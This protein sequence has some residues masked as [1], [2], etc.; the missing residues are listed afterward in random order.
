MT[1]EK[2]QALPSTDVKAVINGEI[3]DANTA[4]LMGKGKTVLFGLPGAF[5]PTCSQ[6]HLP[7]YVVQ[8]DA[9]KA[10]GVDRVICMSVNDGFVM[11]AWGEASNA[12][13][14]IMLADG[15]GDFAQALGLEMDASGFMMG[16]RCKRFAMIIEDG[17][18]TGVFVEAPKEFEVSSAEYIL[19]QL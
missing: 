9:L 11:K 5:T 4:D 8:F 16:S 13:N 15:N 6:S 18:V 12:E 1:I 10:K 7:G 3:E 17:V 14:L 19:T 2:N